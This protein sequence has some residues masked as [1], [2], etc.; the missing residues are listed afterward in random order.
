MIITVG[1]KK[2]MH[3]ATELLSKQRM[4]IKNESERTCFQICL[5]PIKTLII[6]TRMDKL[7][8]TGTSFFL[9]FLRDE[10]A[11]KLRR[12]LT[13]EQYKNPEASKLFTV[14]YIDAPL[15][16]QDVLFK[17]LMKQGIMKECDADIAAAH[18]YAPIY[19]MLSLCDGFPEREQEALDFIRR[20]I[21]QFS[22]LYM[23]EIKGK[24]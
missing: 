18:F 1:A 21:T 23:K 2:Y 4:V 11:R 7:I 6:S 24:R 5:T 12:M 15:Q 8:Q 9:Y 13:I 14:Q 3:L 22:K 19:L 16:Y 10:T 17:A 20:H